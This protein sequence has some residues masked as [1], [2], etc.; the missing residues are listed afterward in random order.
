MW[1]SFKQAG[2][3]SSKTAPLAAA[4][5][6]EGQLSCRAEFLQN[7]AICDRIISFHAGTNFISGSLLWYTVEIGY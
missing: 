7:R 5:P 2:T 6:P 4:M 1:Y 3:R